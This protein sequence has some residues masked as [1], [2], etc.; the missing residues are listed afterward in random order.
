MKISVRT[1][2]S[3]DEIRPRRN[4]EDPGTV[5]RKTESSRPLR[6]RVSTH[7]PRD[8]ES[9]GKIP[10]PPNQGGSLSK[11]AAVTSPKTDIFR[12]RIR[13][14]SHAEMQPAALREKTLDESK[15]PSMIGEAGDALT[16]RASENT[17]GGAAM[18]SA[19]ALSLSVNQRN[20]GGS[21]QKGRVRLVLSRVRRGWAS[22]D[23]ARRGILRLPDDSGRW[24]GFRT[25]KHRGKIRINF[26]HEPLSTGSCAHDRW[27]TRKIPTVRRV[28]HFSS[29]EAISSPL[30]K[31]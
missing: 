16:F 14:A 1:S 7:I 13:T 6:A 8:K 28:P 29:R 22:R 20:G 11:S 26:S 27:D 19:L 17:M 15:P 24:S 25:S 31:E 3:R 9:E 4:G 30:C 2:F 18:V 23:N 12:R 5:R 21:R 10:P